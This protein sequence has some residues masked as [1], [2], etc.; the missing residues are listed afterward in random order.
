MV[1]GGRDGGGGRHV[2]AVCGRRLEQDAREK[3]EEG[4]DRG[5]IGT[6]TDEMFARRGTRRSAKALHT[7]NTHAGG[8]N[9]IL[10]TQKEDY[11]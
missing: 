11:H 10:S 2:C 5:L 7:T 6:R 9:K 8:G 4:V 3:D 1:G